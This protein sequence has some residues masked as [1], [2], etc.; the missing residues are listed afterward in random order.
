MQ[1]IVWVKR[2]SK[3]VFDNKTPINVRLDEG[4]NGGGGAKAAVEIGR[5]DF[6]FKSLTLGQR[7]TCSL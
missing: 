3:T 2:S 6:L 5:Q 4:L 7:V 1:E